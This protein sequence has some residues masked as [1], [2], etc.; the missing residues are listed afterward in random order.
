VSVVKISNHVIDMLNHNDDCNGVTYWSRCLDPYWWG[1]EFKAFG[2]SQILYI[3]CSQRGYNF[4]VDVI[5]FCQWYF[6]TGF[7]RFM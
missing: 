1:V 2:E 5:V 3:V 4:C 6:R 7:P